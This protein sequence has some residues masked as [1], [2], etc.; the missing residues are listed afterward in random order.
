ME[1]IEY[2]L[3]GYG[4]LRVIYKEEP[5]VPEYNDITSKSN[6]NTVSNILHL[7]AALDLAQDNRYEYENLKKL[8]NKNAEMLRIHKDKSTMSYITSSTIFKAIKLSMLDNKSKPLLRDYSI[9]NIGLF[10]GITNKSRGSINFVSLEQ[11]YKMIYGSTL[12]RP[13][14]VGLG[15]S[16]FH[17]N[18][19]V[20]LNKI[21]PNELSTVGRINMNGDMSGRLT[22]D[23]SHNESS[24][25][26]KNEIKYRMKK[27]DKA[28]LENVDSCVVNYVF[29][30]IT[31]LNQS[32]LEEHIV[33]Y[34]KDTDIP[35]NEAL[36]NIIFATEE[37]KLKGRAHICL[38]QCRMVYDANIADPNVVSWRES[39][40]EYISNGLLENDLL[41]IPSIHPDV[42][43]TGVN[44]SIHS[45]DCTNEQPMKNLDEGMYVFTTCSDVD[46][47]TDRLSRLAYKDRYG[48]IS[49]IRNTTLNRTINYYVKEYQDLG[50]SQ[51]SID[52]FRL[53]LVERLKDK[54]F[55]IEY[56]RINFEFGSNFSCPIL[57]H[58]R[59]LGFEYVTSDGEVFE[60]DDFIN[61]FKESLYHREEVSDRNE[62]NKFSAK[63]DTRYN[64]ELNYHG[65]E[66][67]KTS[68]ICFYR[69]KVHDMDTFTEDGIVYYD[70][71]YMLAF[72]HCGDVNK[73]FEFN[74]SDSRDGDIKLVSNTESKKLYAPILGNVVTIN[75]VTDK[76]MK[77]GLYVRTVE[78]VKRVSQKDY[79]SM[80]IFKTAKGVKDY[81]LAQN[82]A[83][84]NLDESVDILRLKNEEFR[85]KMEVRNKD[86]KI[87]EL[88][89][90]TK[91]LKMQ[92]KAND[93][94][95]KLKEAELK[96]II[97]KLE[98]MGPLEAL[99]TY[100]KCGLDVTKLCN[101]F[102]IM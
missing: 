93:T 49:A 97:R 50:Y 2:S 58:Y 51:D 9:G 15:S 88:E 53:R 35:K 72:S 47:K 5:E 41:L 96:D 4:S 73:L 1:L 83:M 54:L 62:L 99:Q 79:K 66:I 76:N 92:G 45:T 71:D 11:S 8:A 24:S 34:S 30:N 12:L 43:N 37:S 91:L 31:D 26:T 65:K 100:L 39:I 40:G 64:S 22:A 63:F 7:E 14:F 86:Y 48:R 19:D 21:K 3:L 61:E 52:K 17:H 85:N 87:A 74:Q 20:Y 56:K 60:V 57:E 69:V 68:S 32:E 55:V 80:G 94:L 25:L 82:V 77:D 10:G 46:K 29:N 98:D 28:I 27:G 16:S 36:K 42:V 59:K 33:Q 102:G 90:M 44:F 38:E 89:S 70:R 101:N 75:S 18:F 81:L 6:V 13:L 67:C 23:F 95:S 84:N 78:G